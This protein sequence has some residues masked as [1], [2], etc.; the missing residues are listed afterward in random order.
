MK[1]FRLRLFVT[2]A[3]RI[4]G[5]NSIARVMRKLEKVTFAHFF[6]KIS[7]V[8]VAFVHTII[9]YTPVANGYEIIYNFDRYK[10]ILK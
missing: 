7:P 6:K 3:C 9:A 1:F 8:I 5:L 2:F 4:I 10:I